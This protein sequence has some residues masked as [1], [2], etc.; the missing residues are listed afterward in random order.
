MELKNLFRAMKANDDD[1]PIQGQ[2][3]RTLGA[4]PGTDIPLSET[5]T[6]APGSGGMSVAPDDPGNLPNH[7]RPPSLGG[8]GRDP[9]FKIQVD[10]LPNSLTIN[11]DKPTHAM[12][13]PA[14][15]CLFDF[16]QTEIHNTQSDWTIS[17]V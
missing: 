7:R 12:I 2:S 6:V 4:R 8:D 3:G 13:E 11:Q 14:C 17:H 1:L 5:E 10:L 15:E 9:V 16:Y